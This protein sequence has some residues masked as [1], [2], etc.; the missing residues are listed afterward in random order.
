MQHLRTGPSDPF[1]DRF[2]RPRFFPP[3]VNPHPEK[4]LILIQAGNSMPAEIDGK[5]A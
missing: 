3:L 1:G 5:D 2:L 4:P